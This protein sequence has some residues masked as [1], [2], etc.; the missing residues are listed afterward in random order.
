MPWQFLI[1]GFLLGL[2]GS[3]HCVGMC[4]P[5]A[6]ALPVRLLPKHQKV[7]GIMLYNI[8][9][10]TTYASLGLTVGV[11]GKFLLIGEIQQWFTIVFGAGILVVLILSFVFKKSMHITA[12]NQLYNKLQ[13]FIAKRMQQHG[14]G[15]LFILGIA[16]GLLPCGMVFLALTG[17]LTAASFSDSMIYMLLY[18]IG[19]LPAMFAL[20]YFGFVVN[21]SLR[22]RVK[23]FAPVFLVLIAVLL[24][25]RG[26]N[27]N[28]PY[29]S[30]YFYQNTNKAVLCH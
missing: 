7:F 9:R 10:V 27:L 3:A 23:K 6:F 30:P 17:A 16:N 22:N 5:I 1:S 2:V 11:L 29:V 15:T 14:L 20:T 13:L 19:T 4:G 8:G 12:L 21:V 18:G 25:L 24:I 26:F 28:I